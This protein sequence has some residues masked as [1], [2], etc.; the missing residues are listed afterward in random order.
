MEGILPDVVRWNPKKFDNAAAHQLRS[1][2]L[3][4]AEVYREPLLERRDNP[5][6]D[7]GVLLAEQDRQQRLPPSPHGPPSPA[8]PAPIGRGAWLAFTRLQPA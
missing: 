3:E 2:L 1:V 4:P 8:P 5:L 6:V 7:V